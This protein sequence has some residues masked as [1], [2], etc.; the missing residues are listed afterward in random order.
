MQL[1]I[2]IVKMER[3]GTEFALQPCRLHL[4]GTGA[5]G[6]DS[7]RFLLPE[8][9]ADKTVNLYTEWKNGE[10]PIPKTLDAE[11]TVTVDR[12]FTGA[13]SGKWMLAVTGAG[14]KACTRPGSYECHK[15]LDTDA[16][17]TEI[18]Q[19]MYE[20]FVARVLSSAQ[21]VENNAKT[22]LSASASAQS[23]AQTA[24]AAAES[25]AQNGNAAKSAADRAEAAAAR[26]EGIAP[27]GGS[28]MSVNGKG[29]AVVL[30]AGDVGAVPQPESPAA[31]Q[32]LRVK[33]VAEDGTMTVE[34][35]SAETVKGNKSL[36]IVS[37]KNAS[38]LTYDGSTETTWTMSAEWI[39]AAA[40]E[41][42]H[43]KSQVTDLETGLVFTKLWE[44]TDESGAFAGQTITLDLTGYD[45]VAVWAKNGSNTDTELYG[46]IP[47]QTKTNSEETYEIAV[48]RITS[49]NLYAPNS[50]TLKTD[51][52]MRLF[53]ASRDRVEFTDTVFLGQYQG[54]D[55]EAAGVCIPLR[56]Y[57]VKGI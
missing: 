53:A 36:K 16:E 45:G 24:G 47:F 9:W 12:T 52:R 7:L 3:G 20:Q 21:S 57:G 37:A 15:T 30:S 44:N 51:I 40:L 17:N 14:Y 38:V 2:E 27:E 22:A 33:A 11:G 50:S 8:E 34:C 31:G 10:M 29:G 56:I 26:A 35:V 42:T 25:A 13:E 41:H 6:V 23:A 39:G 49:F 18:S 43:T 48:G 32:L 4:G 54:T 55:S 46:P 1:T 5:E 28:V 19:T